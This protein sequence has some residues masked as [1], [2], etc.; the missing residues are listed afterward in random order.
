MQSQN[1][2]RAEVGVKRPP[3]A[4]RRATVRQTQSNARTSANRTKA[5]PTISV[6]PIIVR[7]GVVSLNGYGV[8][9]AV[10]KGHLSVAD[11][12]GSQ[13]RAARFSRATCG[14]KRLVV[15]GS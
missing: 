2:R 10:E 4:G 12:I 7:E 11:G 5:P 15:R 13:R 6:E 8:R 1:T 9:I 14:L 3:F